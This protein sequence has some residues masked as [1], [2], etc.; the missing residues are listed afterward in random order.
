MFQRIKGKEVYRRCINRSVKFEMSLEFD[1]PVN[2]GRWNYATERSKTS[3]IFCAKYPRGFDKVY[4]GELDIAQ[5]AADLGC[6]SCLLSD[7]PSITQV[8]LMR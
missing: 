5:V 3:E 8:K 6:A 7:Q 2:D 4:E 1:S